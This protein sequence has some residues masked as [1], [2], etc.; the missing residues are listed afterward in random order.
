MIKL[1]DV[2]NDPYVLELLKE[3]DTT[4]KTIG[5]TEHGLVHAT[6]V[7]KIAQ[8]LCN[9]FGFDKHSSE[10]TQVA[11]FLHDIGNLAGR[12]DHGQ[13]GASLATPH[14][15]RLGVEP[16]ELS[17][18]LSAIANH[19]DLEP[20]IT[21]KISAVVLIADKSDVRRSRVRDTSNLERIKNDIH[22]RVNYAVL[23]SKLYVENSDV[24]LSVNL[25]SD[26][27]GSADYLDIFAG[28]T[29]VVREASKFLGH[30]FHLLIDNVRI[31]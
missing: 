27:A 3:S 24:V 18:I 7:S 17:L 21:S 9:S 12:R 28:R 14:L 29:R 5:Y 22:D 4:T 20:V 23:S 10:V 19:D 30:N 11:A 31:Y 6:T 1:T 15:L 16:K 13:I 26:F 8:Y 25:D 2:K